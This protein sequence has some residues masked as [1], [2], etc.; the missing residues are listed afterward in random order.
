MQCLRNMYTTGVLAE[1][2]YW[3]DG[4]LQ[5]VPLVRAR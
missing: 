4:Q 2:T 3:C 5:T 1:L